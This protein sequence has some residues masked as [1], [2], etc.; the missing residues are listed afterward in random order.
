MENLRQMD[1]NYVSI[2][3]EW[4][5]RGKSYLSFLPLNPMLG[6]GGHSRHKGL[7]DRLFVYPHKN[8]EGGGGGAYK[9]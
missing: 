8:E 9:V 4:S 2:S 5:I 6:G 1:V 7:W 3:G